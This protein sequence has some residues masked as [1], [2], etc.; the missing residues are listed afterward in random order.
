M[1]LRVILSLWNLDLPHWD[2]VQMTRDRIKKAASFK[3][4]E[5]TSVWGKKLFTISVKTILANVRCFHLFKSCFSVDLTVYIVCK[6]GTGKYLC[7]E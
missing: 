5:S 4:V 6:T 2:T 3:I 7:C 1:Q